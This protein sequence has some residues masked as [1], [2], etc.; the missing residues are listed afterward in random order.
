MLVRFY[1]ICW[2]D[3]A[4]DDLPSSVTL[5][6]DDETDENDIEMNGSEML[7][8]EFGV[9]CESCEFEKLDEDEEDVDPF[10]LIQEP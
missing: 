6:I 10:S 3:S 5:E 2:A 8:E 9:E 4:D 7:F 1:S